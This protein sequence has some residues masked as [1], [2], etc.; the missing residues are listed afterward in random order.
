MKRILIADDDNDLRATIVD[1]LSSSGFQVDEASNGIEAI[2]KIASSPYDIALIDMV[3][4]R[5]TGLELLSEIKR[6][7]PGTKIIIMTAFATVDNA[8]E[9]IKRGAS[10]YIKKPFRLWELLSVV[11]KTIEEKRFEDE[12]RKLNMDQAFTS[13]SNPIRRS[14]LRMLRSNSGM[15]L[16][17]ITDTLKIADNTK[18]SYHLR[19]LIDSGLVFQDNKKRYCLTLEGEKVLESLKLLGQYLENSD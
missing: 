19:M 5:V 10:D 18:V 15:R 7:S 3:M 17:E 11:N 14:I 9:A 12:T 16:S 4:P 6:I 13:L 8:V 1:A 2:E